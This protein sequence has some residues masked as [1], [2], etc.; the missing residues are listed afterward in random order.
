MVSV[1]VASVQQSELLP[2]DMQYV[3]EKYEVCMYAITIELQ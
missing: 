3:S 1:A 2:S